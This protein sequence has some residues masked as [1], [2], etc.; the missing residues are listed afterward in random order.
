[1]RMA[2]GKINDI[3]AVRFKKGENVLKGIKKICEDNDIKNA[4]IISMIGSVEGVLYSYPVKDEKKESGIRASG[5]VWHEGPAIMLT[6]QGHISHKDD[7]ELYVHLHGTFADWEGNAYGGNI[8]GEDMTTLLTL[9]IIIG[10]ID[11]ID[12]GMEFDE[13]V[14]GEV[15]SPRNV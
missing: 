5:G 14:G 2:T 11:G 3:I 10:V 8:D 12:M 9:E 4:V 15:F 6:A 7:G 13:T 1:M